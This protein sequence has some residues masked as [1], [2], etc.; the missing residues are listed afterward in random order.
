MAA[1]NRSQLIERAR[2]LKDRAKRD[3]G[4]EAAAAVRAYINFLREHAISQAEL[5]PRPA[6]AAQ[7]PPRAPS[8]PAGKPAPAR[9][10]QS[11]KGPEK[12]GVPVRI[13]I[14]GIEVRFRL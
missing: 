14:G 7:S 9:T 4:P 6:R 11:N 2:K 5:D 13:K 10:L 8:K 3:I 1:L 12:E